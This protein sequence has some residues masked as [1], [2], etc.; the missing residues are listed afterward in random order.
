MNNLYIRPQEID[1]GFYL[2]V[3]QMRPVERAASPIID[4]SIELTETALAARDWYRGE[5][6]VVPMEY[7][8]LLLNPDTNNAASNIA[9]FVE[10]VKSFE[11]G[12]FP[13]HCN[14][15]R[16]LEFTA[17]YLIRTL[18]GIVS[19]QPVFA[20]A[21]KQLGAFF[22]T[23]SDPAACMLSVHDYVQRVDA[24]LAGLLDAYRG[25]SRAFEQREHEIK[26][27]ASGSTMA[28]ET[29]ALARD[30]NARVK[31]IDARGA[32]R[33]GGRKEA[34]ERQEACFRYWELGLTK[35]AV[36][37]ASNGRP[38]HEDVFDYYRRELAEIGVK[39]S[40]E[41]KTLLVRRQKRLSQSV[42]ATAPK[43]NTAGQKNGIIHAMKPHAKSALSLALA[44]V[45]GM[46]A[47]MRPA[48]V[49]ISQSRQTWQIN[50]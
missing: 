18:S 17:T 9:G 12:A 7:L 43:T 15:V 41:F 46:A 50:S 40:E 21:L 1:D 31:R 16:E 2:R 22:A 33:R 48:A 38:R 32:D 37:N 29:L 14:A 10:T 42:Q 19:A 11:P 45:G 13:G 6:L 34:R 35:E 3:R 44:I 20:N 26:F 24:K 30:T 28:A 4:H 5:T 36:R 49:E 39:T 47:G 8:S 27:G 25:I 23:I